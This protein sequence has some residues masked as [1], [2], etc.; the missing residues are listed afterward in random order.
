MIDVGYVVHFHRG[1]VGKPDVHTYA[2]E[3][4][5]VGIDAE[6]VCCILLATAI[7]VLHRIDL[8]VSAMSE[9][10][11][12]QRLVVAKRVGIGK[13]VPSPFRHAAQRYSV[14][15]F[16]GESLHAREVDCSS[17]TSVADRKRSQRIGCAN[18]GV[19]AIDHSF[20]VYGVGDSFYVVTHL[21]H[22][23]RRPDEWAY[24]LGVVVAYGL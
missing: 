15:V 16:I 4:Q 1:P 7:F 20:A 5:A 14:P 22:F 19:I 17:K 2:S 3:I 13:S 9:V 8:A 12:A 11:V 18:Y 6:I 23:E 24:A 21:L 10:E